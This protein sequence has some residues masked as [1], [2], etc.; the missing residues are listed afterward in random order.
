MENR[1]HRRRVKHTRLATACIGSARETSAAS[2]ESAVLIRC[3][4]LP[5][6]R[7]SAG[8]LDVFTHVQDKFATLIGALEHTKSALRIGPTA[9]QSRTSRCSRRARL[10]S[11]MQCCFTPS[12]HE[13]FDCSKQF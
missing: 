5:A 11:E 6:I 3:A 13:I 4:D 8:F 10:G 2:N 9:E 1:S 12:E 7:E